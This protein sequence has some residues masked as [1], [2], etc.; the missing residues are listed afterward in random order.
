[1]TVSETMTRNVTCCGPD[2]TL[3]EAARM[4]VEHDCG[5][6]PVTAN[7]DGSGRL[8]GMITDRDMVVR[9]IAHGM[10]G[11]NTTVGQCMSAD[12]VCARPEMSLE[13]CEQMMAVHQVRRIPVCDESGSCIG[14]VAQADVALSAPSQQIATV[15]RQL[16]KPGIA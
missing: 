14:M 2:A 9:C 3:R 12:V 4:M 7:A 1:M 15:L 13:E 16:S 10:D 11:N 6:L 5:S 8:I